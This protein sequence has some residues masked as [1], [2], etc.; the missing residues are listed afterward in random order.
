MYYKN[1]KI[2]EPHL[3]FVG[4]WCPLHKGHIC[5]VKSVLT[6]KKLPI[7]ILVRNT[8]FDKISVKKRAKIV[9]L[10]MK[11]EHISGSVMIIPDI[12]GIYYGRGVGYDIDEIKPPE[13]IKT[14]SATKIR[15]LIKQNDNSW[16]SLV[17]NGTI[18]YLRKIL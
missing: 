2:K 14:V 12:E 17:A 6:Q 15:E 18:K 9:K 1:S 7:L 5:I 3:V 13:N 11:A 8:S 16:E 10:W 4:R